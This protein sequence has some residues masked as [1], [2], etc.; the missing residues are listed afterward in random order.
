MAATL[1]SCRRGSSFHGALPNS[2]AIRG[3]A[4]V[5]VEAGGEPSGIFGI[6]ISQGHSMRVELLAR[7][8]ILSLGSGPATLA[9]SDSHRVRKCDAGFGRTIIGKLLCFFYR[10]KVFPVPLRPVDSSVLACF[11][12]S[13]HIFRT[14]LALFAIFLTLLD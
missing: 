14:T 13:R 1:E 3:C 12:R 2:I 9:S 5:P 11:A 6:G 7:A 4:R 8:S 10:L